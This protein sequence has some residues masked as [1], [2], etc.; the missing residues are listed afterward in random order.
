VA[1]IAAALAL[2]DGMF[3]VNARIAMNDTYVAFF[4]VAA[5]TAFA[6]LYMEHWRG[7]SA[8]LVGIPLVAVLLGLALASKWVGAYAIGAVLLL[9]LL[10]SALGRLLALT[11]MI[12]LSGLLGYLAI[13]VPSGP[14]NPQRNV[15]F[16]VLLV[17]L[18]V[19]LG[20]AIVVRPVRVT[21]AEHRYAFAAMFGTGAL[22]ALAGLLLRASLP[23]DGL[24]TFRNLLILGTLLMLSGAGTLVAPRIGEQLGFRPFAAPAPGEVVDPPS[25]APS[26]W[27]NPGWARG[28]PWTWA[29]GC[30]AVIPLV[31]YV[32]S[33]IPWAMPWH[34]AGPRLADAWPLI[35]TWPPGHTGQTLLDLQ[36]GMYDYHN[37]LRATHAASSPWW[38]WPLDLKPVWFYSQGFGEGGT[39]LIYDAGNMVAFWLAIPAMAWAAWQAWKRRSLALTFLVITVAALWLPWARIDRATFQYHIFTSLP[40]AFL[41]LAY[42]LAELW[43]GPGR[44]TWA[45]ARLAGAGALILP[46]FMW[47]TR[48][49]L[50]GLAATEKVRPGGQACGSVTEQFVLS[51][52]W[53]VA[54]LIGVIGLGAVL[55]QWYSLRRRQTD[56]MRTEDGHDGRPTEHGDEPRSETNLARRWLALTAVAAIAAVSLALLGL[57]ERSVVAFTIGDRSPYLV[58]LV[59]LVVL[60]VPA[61]FIL[62]A[63]DPRR[64]VVVALGAAALWFLAFYPYLSG[65]PVP[66]GIAAW[67][68]TLPLPTWNYDFQFAVNVDPPF[69]AQALLPSSLALAAG[70]GALCLAA[71]YAANAWRLELARR[72]YE[73]AAEAAEP[74]EA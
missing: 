16:L 29:L 28:I 30:L 59:A 12:G 37:N 43:H 3:F 63:R 20:I 61:L 46:A 53:A 67:Y 24:L 41:A 57:S 1:L 4:I 44:G 64:F 54:L 13:A 26:G 49:V 72:R 39:G 74:A 22:T 38:A 27:L 50:C 47:L 23:G 71:M 25:P 21:P 69:R 7:P 51:E 10:R 34:P 36:V 73:S 58:A 70:V 2:V 60:A 5:F 68:Q 48:P 8:L 42:F 35:G 31:V 56:G 66:P 15:L 62:E 52:R 55:W 6:L 65:L 11:G 14:E 17:A 18:T 40:F 9:V 33:Y 45:L 19:L 32:I